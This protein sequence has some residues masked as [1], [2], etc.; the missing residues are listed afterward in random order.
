MIKIQTN[1]N[2][3]TELPEKYVK[4]FKTIEDFVSV[5][6]GEVTIPLPDITKDDLDIVIKYTDDILN[7]TFN[8]HDDITATKLLTIGDYLA[9][10]ILLDKICD[11]IAESI[12]GKQPQEL[13]AKLNLKPLNDSEQQ[14]ILDKYGFL[15]FD[16]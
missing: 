12:K 5:Y 16:A 2:I 1:D 7:N 13:A 10:E 14:N 4:Y 6:G 3:V 8:I 11:Y 15:L 9:N